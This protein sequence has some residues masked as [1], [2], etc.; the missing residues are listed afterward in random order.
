MALQKP[1]S[2]TLASQALSLAVPSPPSSPLQVQP[3]LRGGVKP[4]TLEKLV[5]T[6]LNLG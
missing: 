3:V 4:G 2:P 1:S 6:F 5:L